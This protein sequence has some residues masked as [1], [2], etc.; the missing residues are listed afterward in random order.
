MVRGSALYAIYTVARQ[1]YSSFQ[2]KFLKKKKIYLCWFAY[3]YSV[4]NQFLS[5]WI[6]N[7]LVFQYRYNKTLE[8]YETSRHYSSCM[9]QSIYEFF[10]NEEWPN[11]NCEIFHSKKSSEILFQKQKLGFICILKGLF[12]NTFDT[13]LYFHY[14]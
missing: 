6:E 13:R 14:R 7:Y 11:R 9:K 5:T 12:A 2:L 1:K 3:V 4:N 10:F 8:M